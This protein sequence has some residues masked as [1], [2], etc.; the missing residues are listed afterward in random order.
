MK[1][2]AVAKNSFVN[3]LGQN[4][5]SEYESARLEQN[6]VQAQSHL[7]DRNSQNEDMLIEGI[8][9]DESNLL[10]NPPG[11]LDEEEDG[12]VLQQNYD[13]DADNLLI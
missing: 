6:N 9:E 4:D 5:L 1:E 2:T 8:T 11:F 3:Q 7:I 13:D 10:T 12:D